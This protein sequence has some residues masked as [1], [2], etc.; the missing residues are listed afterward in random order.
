M[1]LSSAE[2]YVKKILSKK[3]IKENVP[4]FDIL[5]ILLNGKLLRMEEILKIEF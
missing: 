1:F 4:A 3:I 5:R 2:Y